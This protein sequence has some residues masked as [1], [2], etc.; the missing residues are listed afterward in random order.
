MTI[1]TGEHEYPFTFQ[2]ATNL[3]SSFETPCGFVRYNIEAIVKRSWKFDYCARTTFTVNALVDL[4]LQTVFMEP[5]ETFKE[6]SI[7]CLCCKE[8][9]ISMRVEMPR[10]GYVPGESVTFSVHS[11]NCSSRPVTAIVVYF[12]RVSV[13]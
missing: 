6:K 10:T 3:P 11:S 9:P 2:L 5:R 12:I 7:C 4:N 13:I 1:P 8:G